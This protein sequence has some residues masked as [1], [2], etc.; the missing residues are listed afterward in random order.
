MMKWRGSHIFLI[1]AV[2]LFVSCSKGGGTTDDGSGGGGGGPHVENPAD[3]VPPVIEITTPSD[4]QVFANGST[5]SISGKLTDDLGLY[6][7]TVRIVNDANGTE[8]KN[9]AYEI[10]GLISYNYSTTYTASVTAISN[11]TITVSFED[12]GNNVSTKSVKVKINP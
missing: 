6:R 4:N 11:Y 7:G 8:L 3:V 2:V 12:H 1:L 10:H 9:Q 5:I